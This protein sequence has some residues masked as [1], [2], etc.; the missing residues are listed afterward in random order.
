MQQEEQRSPLSTS[1]IR[2]S[3]TYGGSARRFTTRRRSSATERIWASSRRRSLNESNSGVKSA[4]RYT[5]SFITELAHE[6]NV[7]VESDGYALPL[8]NWVR[9][10]RTE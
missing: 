9:G 1:Q 6:G 5:P 4:A 3:A 10:L 7:K 8:P 2:A